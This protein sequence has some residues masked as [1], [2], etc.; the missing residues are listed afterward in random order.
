MS[1]NKI[2]RHFL[3]A[4]PVVITLGFFIPSHVFAASLY[5]SPA[6]KTLTVGQTFT[7]TLEVSS[8]DEEM[9]AVSADISFPSSKL[10][11]LSLSQTDSIV[12][13]WVQN[14]T[15]SNAQST[16]DVLLQGVV[17]SPGFLGDQGDVVNIVFQA[18]ARGTA[19]VSFSGFVFVEVC[20]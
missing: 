11:V 16:G 8:A 14:P 3:V 10:R 4:A 17:L 7:V 18:I 2:L 15:F 13:F 6:Q 19:S 20:S 12:N 5:L 9:N 1:L